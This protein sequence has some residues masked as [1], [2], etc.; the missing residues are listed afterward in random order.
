MARVSNIL[1]TFSGFLP[2]KTLQGVRNNAR[3]S[4]HS[5]RQNRCPSPSST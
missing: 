2:G 4:M 5:L 3:G 1:I